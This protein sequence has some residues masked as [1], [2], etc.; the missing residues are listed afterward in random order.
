MTSRHDRQDKK[1]TFGRMGIPKHIPMRELA[2]N[3]SHFGNHKQI[4]NPIIIHRPHVIIANPV[5]IHR[6][7]VI[8]PFIIQ[9]PQV[10]ISIPRHF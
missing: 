8:N 10:V 7:H 4:V 3:V 6:A 2:I 1:S 9:H 5:I